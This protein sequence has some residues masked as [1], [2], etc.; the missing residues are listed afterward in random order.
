MRQQLPGPLGRRQIQFPRALDLFRIE[1]AGRRDDF[2]GR[3]RPLGRAHQDEV[4]NE[5]AFDQARGHLLRLDTAAVGERTLVI[6][7][8]RID[9]LR[10]TVPEQRQSARTHR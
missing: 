5:I 8:I 2:R 1:L 10:F 6:L 7:R 3:P 4:R 9:G